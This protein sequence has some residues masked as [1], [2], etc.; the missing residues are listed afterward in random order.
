MSLARAVPPPAA[1]VLF[2][3]N[4][5]KYGP[6]SALYDF[7]VFED[8]TTDRCKVD[9]EVTNVEARGDQC[10]TANN[11]GV[12][13]CVPPRRF[14]AACSKL[15]FLQLLVRQRCFVFFTKVL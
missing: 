2:R 13:F 15:P 3:H 10:I 5:C 12:C 4:P 6:T 8:E 11:F 9:L 7:D 1:V 14:I